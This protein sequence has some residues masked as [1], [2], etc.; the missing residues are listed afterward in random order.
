MKISDII[1]ED[2]DPADTDKVPN[3]VYQIM[4]SLDTDGNKPIIFNDGTKETIP[5]NMLLSFAK[6]YMSL[7]PNDREELQNIASQSKE[8]FIKS[9]KDFKGQVAPKSIY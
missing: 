9:L 5:M 2:I 6:R 7:K 3:L 4:K 1:N 8:A